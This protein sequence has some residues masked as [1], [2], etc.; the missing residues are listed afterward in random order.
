[1]QVSKYTLSLSVVVLAIVGVVTLTIQA[2]E[3][4]VRGRAAQPAPA[5][6][7]ESRDV[8]LP[9]QSTRLQIDVFELMCTHDQ[10]LEVSSDRLE[11]GQDGVD[12][13]TGA[14]LL[15]ALQ[16]FGEARVLFHADNTVELRHSSIVRRGQRVPVV[17]D[18]V[19][20]ADGTRTPSVTYQQQGMI[21]KVEGVWRP[22][23]SPAI[24]HL[25]LELDLTSITDTQVQ[26]SDDVSLP[27]FHS[28][29]LAQDLWVESGR[30]VVILG[31]DFPVV[32]QHGGRTVVL[33]VRVAATRLPS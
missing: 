32:D 25:S 23:P 3:R 1:M 11:G 5:G 20:T 29:K 19:V 8:G 24:A 27:A 15:E 30:P 26:V 14:Q 4:G 6:N 7:L 16:A 31:N 17:Q 9:A 10:L 28:L 2:Q 18:V 21:A 33:I 12:S 22:E 13:L